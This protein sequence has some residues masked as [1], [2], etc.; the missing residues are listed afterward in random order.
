MTQ[1]QLIDHCYQIAGKCVDCDWC[2]RE[3]CYLYSE[4]FGNDPYEDDFFH[5][6]RYVDAEITGSIL[7]E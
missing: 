4:Q 6:D 1:K 2:Y 5:P 7:K 3:E